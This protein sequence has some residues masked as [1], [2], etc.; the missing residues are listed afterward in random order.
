MHSAEC[1]SLTLF[2]MTV[3]LTWS[4][5]TGKVL[6]HL[7]GNEI[8]FYEC[9]GYSI[10][11]RKFE[12]RELGIHFELLASRVA[13]NHADRDFLCYECIINGQAFSELPTI[14]EN[15]LLVETKDGTNGQPL[16]I[17]DGDSYSSS[18]EDKDEDCGTP[19]HLENLR[20]VVDLVYPDGI[21]TFN[22]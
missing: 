6:I 20:S 19:Y 2:P 4:T 1:R 21:P 13:P 15:R 10:L 16:L 12:S 14:I 9:K 11:Q 18:S 7:D 5:Q 17:T 8:D 3:T 22:Y